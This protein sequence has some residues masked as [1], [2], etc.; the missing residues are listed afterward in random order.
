MGGLTKVEK[1]EAK[2]AAKAAG[3]ILTQL[4]KT[5]GSGIAE[6]ANPVSKALMTYGCRNQIAVVNTVQ[7]LAPVSEKFFSMLNETI[8][9]SQD[10]NYKKFD[11]IVSLISQ[12]ENASIET[13][14]QLVNDYL[15]QEH[16]RKIDTLKTVRGGTVAVGGI[17]AAGLCGLK[18]IDAKKAIT[19]AKITAEQAEKISENRSN[20][21]IG[22]A[23]LIFK[24]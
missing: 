13:K 14:I 22:L 6:L 23:K 3:P 2:L 16:S 19:L 7:A 24:G 9:I 5:A 21:I 10:T 17:A 18:H 12:D 20:V 1:A 11:L 4:S 8:K 15:Q